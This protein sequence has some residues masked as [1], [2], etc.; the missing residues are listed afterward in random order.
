[1]KI[2]HLPQ[3]Q[4]VIMACNT[5][6]TPTEEWGM[7]DRLVQHNTKQVMG[8]Y[9]GSMEHSYVCNIN[10]WNSIDTYIDIAQSFKQECILALDKPNHDGSRLAC[11]VYTDNKEYEPIGVF[12]CVGQNCP[13]GDYTFDA[14]SGLYY[15]VR[16]M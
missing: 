2:S 5:S 14:T 12:E 6:K 13:E 1:M 9:K 15:Q 16:G 10:A 4:I 11:L 3:N 8:R 7:V